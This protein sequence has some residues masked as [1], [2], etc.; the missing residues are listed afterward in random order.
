LAPTT[1]Y[2]LFDSKDDLVTAYVTSNA[3]PYK[4]WVAEATRPEFGSPVS[5]SSPSSTLWPSRSSPTAAE[6]ALSS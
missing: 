2:R 5:G 1:L 3:E 4:V 6:A